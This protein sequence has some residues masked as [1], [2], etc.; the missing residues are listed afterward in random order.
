M[1]RRGSSTSLS[2]PSLTTSHCSTSSRR[3]CARGKNMKEWLSTNKRRSVHSTSPC[4]CW[5][6]RSAFPHRNGNALS[7][8]KRFVVFVV[9]RCTTNTSGWICVLRRRNQASASKTQ[10]LA[11]RSLT[12][13]PNASCNT[14]CMSKADIS[15]KA[16]PSMRCAIIAACSECISSS[17]ILSLKNS[18]AHWM[19][20]SPR[21]SISIRYHGW[22]LD[23]E[24]AAGFTVKKHSKIDQGT[25]LKPV[26]CLENH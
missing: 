21:L 1:S 25:F 8:T 23:Q 16:S 5:N 2:N 9:Q 3:A 4:A 26:L 12:A 14:L 24:C 19:V 6:A 7:A 11:L 22:Q 17:E 10:S 15:S 13:T 18:T 20:S